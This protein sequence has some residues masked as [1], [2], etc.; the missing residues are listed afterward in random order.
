MIETFFAWFFGVWLF[1]L[2]PLWVIVSLAEGEIQ[3]ANPLEWGLDVR[4][5]LSLWTIIIWVVGG[6]IFLN[7]A[8]SGKF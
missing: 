5:G 3:S 2:V 6:F 8:A 4:M 7:F 1:P